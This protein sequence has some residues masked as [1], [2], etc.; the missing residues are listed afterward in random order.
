M[1]F[2]AGILLVAELDVNYKQKVIERHQDCK[3]TKQHQ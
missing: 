1:C 2:I 3:D